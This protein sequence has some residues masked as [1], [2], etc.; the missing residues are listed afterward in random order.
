MYNI[1]FLPTY[2][3]YDLSLREKLPKENS[4]STVVENE[5]EEICNLIYQSDYLQIFN[6]TEYNDDIINTEINR[7][8]KIVKDHS[9]FVECMK[10]AAGMFLSEDL[11]VGLMALFSYDYLFATHLCICDILVNNKI[12]EKN[13]NLLTTLVF[14]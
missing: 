5:N 1:H 7:L 9:N 14:E 13:I 11:E 6:I 3:Y 8:F 10:K 2:V 4:V 12:Q